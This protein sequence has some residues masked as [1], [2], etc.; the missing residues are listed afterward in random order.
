MVKL[1]FIFV[2]LLLIPFSLGAYEVNSLVDLIEENALESMAPELKIF[3]VLTL[4]SLIP[5][6][7]IAMTAFTRIVIVLSLLRQALGL[8]QTPPNSVILTLSLF[9]TFFTMYPAYEKIEQEALVPYLEGKVKLGEAI[10]NASI[11][12]RHFMINQTREKDLAMIIELAHSER[13]KVVEDVKMVHLI[14]AFLLS[15]LKTAFKIAFV[16]FL[17]FLLID[18]VVASI[19]MSLGMIMVPPITIAMPIKIMIFVLIDGWSL[20]TQ[21]LLSSF[22]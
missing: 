21:S 2:V 11:P 5:A 12:L 16:I 22:I 19:L 9:L 14:P 8:Q 3:S 4:L 15:E 13:P 18:L 6:M 20:V 1:L 17:P 10:T 7:L